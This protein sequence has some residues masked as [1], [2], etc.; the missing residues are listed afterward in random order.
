MSDTAVCPRVHAQG[1]FTAERLAAYASL[2]EK[3]EM[4]ELASLGRSLYGLRVQQI[5][6]ARYG[7]GVAEMLQSL[8][9]FERALGLDVS[10]DVIAAEPPFFIYT[11]TLHNFLQG[12]PCVPDL[13]GTKAYWDTNRQNYALVRE[14]ADVII[15]HDPQPAGLIKFAPQAVRR[16][17]KWIW[18]CHIHLSRE[19]QFVLE[20]IRSLIEE[21]DLV[22]FSAGKFLPR[23]KVASAVILP[24]IDPLSDKNRDLPPEQ[25]REICS[26]YGLVDLEAKPLIV[27]VSRFD[28]FKGHHYALE[29]FRLVREEMPCQLLMVGGTASDDP[30]NEAI[31]AELKAQVEGMPDVHLLNLP[32]DSHTEINAFQR[33][34]RIILQPS[35]KEGFGLTVSEG[36]W[37]EKPVIGGDVGGIPSQITDGYNGFL[38]PPGKK[39][40][41]EMADRI[42]YLLKNP[43]FA[44]E[45]GKRGKEAVK[46]RFFLTRGVLDELR[47]IQGLLEG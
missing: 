32:A 40:V 31:F 46:E 20:F 19:H 38:V 15:V 47:L 22:V 29:A 37:K 11:K 7:G 23:W 18:R 33:A 1:S 10:W 43:H 25:I 26:R 9:P 2:V 39:G 12:R 4:D 16:R 44:R 30:E 17:Q 28:P 21:Y 42:K 5:N 41:E 35:I 8:I 6:S 27:L 34:A 3:E 13:A 24:Y 14:D 36:M 45:M